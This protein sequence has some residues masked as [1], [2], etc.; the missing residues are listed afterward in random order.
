MPLA[1]PGTRYVVHIPSFRLCCFFRTDE[2]YTQLP[3]SQRIVRTHSRHIHSSV[4]T[5]PRGSYHVWNKSTLL[6]HKLASLIP[7]STVF[8]NMSGKVEVGVQPGPKP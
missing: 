4:C 6:K 2:C 7:T 5:G 8:D 3:L 1:S